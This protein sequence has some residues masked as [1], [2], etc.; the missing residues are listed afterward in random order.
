MNTLQFAQIGTLTVIA[1]TGSAFDIKRRRLPNWLCLFALVIGL[2]MAFLDTG[3]QAFTS[4]ALHAL[5]A[6]AVGMVLFGLGTIGAGDAK[7]YAALASWF[8]IGSAPF[9]I[10][11]TA[12]AG[13][14]L[15]IVWFPLRRLAVH[16][17]SAGSLVGKDAFGK[18]PFGV[19]I[20]A[21]AVLLQT[22]SVL[23]A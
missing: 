10:L 11:S 23:A 6:L 13:L 17:L 21:G 5:V 22:A 16:S 15:L 1:V 7:F 9:F 12:L 3:S 4:N 18:L 2:G 19:A 14:V 8:T 20:G